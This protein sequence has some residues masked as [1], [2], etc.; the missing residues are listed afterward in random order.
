MPRLKKIISAFAA[1]AVLA[2]A[3]GLT[4]ALGQTAQTSEDLRRLRGG[5]EPGQSG[6]YEAAT[7]SRNG[8]DQGTADG[9]FVTDPTDPL[10]DPL[11]DPL[12]IADVEAEGTVR[13]VSPQIAQD[14]PYAA[15]GIP[16]GSFLLFPEI[17]VQRVWDDNPFLSAS[18]PQGDWALVLNPSLQV[19][20]NWSRHSLSAELSGERSHH[21]R[22]TGENEESYAAG[23]AGRLDIRRDTNLVAGARYSQSLEDRSS[24][25]FPAG[26]LER[27]ITRNK[28]ASLEANHGFNRVTLTLRG[29]L[30]EEDFDD[31]TAIGGAVINNDDRDLVE[32]RVT[33]RAA[34]E[35]MPD[36]AAFAQASVNERIFA[37]S[38][39]DDG[40]R[41]GSSGY[42]MQAGVSFQLTGKLTGEISA[43]YTHQTPDDVTLS[44]IDGLILNAGLEW[45]ATG[46]TI[47]R[48][49]AASSVNETTQ[50]GSAGSIVRSAVVSVEHRPRR[51]ILVG[52]SLGY[53]REE[54]S[55]SDSV[56]ED[57]N[58]ELTGEYNITRS[59]A[60]TAAY[61]Y[62][63]SFSSTPDSGYVVNKIRLGVRLRR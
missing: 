6:N 58:L 35:F 56:D 25:D 1:L 61:S 50:A 24:T 60:L 4:P 30:F 17:T 47:V 16:M 37:E 21:E 32:R 5:F 38:F 57:I 15:L 49:D 10:R 43:G 9:I 34:Y 20:S 27:T 7:Q 40:T 14:D 18:D 11:R 62:H 44:V 52:A 51:H 63:E 28:S 54:F 45:Q 29:E 19:R 3:A 46:L 39:D 8:E 26:A 33:G 31:G 48:L 41:N 23:V 2:A 22:F 55:G 53:E 13:R 42:N 36:V 59:A 12:L